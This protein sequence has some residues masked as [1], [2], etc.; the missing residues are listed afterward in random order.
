M[1]MNSPFSNKGL[2][3]FSNVLAVILSLLAVFSAIGL[4]YLSWKAKKNSFLFSALL[5]EKKEAA[6][7]KS[8]RDAVFQ[9]LSSLGIP[10]DAV[11][12]YRDSE[13]VTHILV[14][15]PLNTYL[16]LEY[17]LEKKFQQTKASVQKKEEQVSEEKNYYLWQVDGPGNQR[18][19][20]LFSCEREGAKKA[21]LPPP[22]KK[23]ANKVALIIDD[24]GYSLH[25]INAVCSLKMPVTVAVLPYSP[26]AKETA[27]IAHQN[28]LDVILHLPLESL[29]NTADNS[30]TEGLIYSRMNKKD[31][32]DTLEK[33]L[34]QVPYIKGVNNH[35]GS[36]V[37]G[38]RTLMGM[39]L[40]RLKEKNLFFVDSRT[41]PDS[42]AYSVAKELGLPSAT[43][44]VFLDG[45]VNEQYIKE[46]LLELFQLAQDKGEAVGIGHPTRETLKVLKE[47]FHLVKRYGLEAVFVS[48]IVR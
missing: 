6:K 40:E 31:M 45:E 24:M 41:T 38:D 16:R 12:Q 14:N 42:V 22:Q 11:N 2:W 25:A 19:T 44:H 13:G 5:G 26:I 27:Q 28:N 29:N 4:D 20:L 36:K 48:E 7:E 17:I 1:R 32:L 47:N 35:M 10:E 8:P 23:T 46:K 9:S 15:L 37:T 30:S 33:D 43:R 21:E 18:L 3:R 34:A 39:I